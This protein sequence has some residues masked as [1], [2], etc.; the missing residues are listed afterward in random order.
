[1]GRFI[2]KLLSHSILAVA[3]SRPKKKPLHDI[4]ADTYVIHEDAWYQ[5][6]GHLHNL[7]KIGPTVARRDCHLVRLMKKGM[8]LLMVKVTFRNDPVTLV[9]KEVSVGDNAPDFT[10]LATDLVPV[11]LADSKGKFD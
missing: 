10:V 8:R 11:S 9:G 4:L 5:K 3:F 7:V 2:S 1:M 6:K